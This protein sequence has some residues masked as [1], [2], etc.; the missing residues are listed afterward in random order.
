[1]LTPVYFVRDPELIKQITIKEFDHFVN[2]NGNIDEEIE[3][4]FGRSL[5]LMRDQRWK[6][7]RS[8]LSPAF[9]GS[10]MRNMFSL[11]ADC[12][13]ETIN[14]L[15]QESNGKPLEIE[16]KDL[17]TRQVILIFDICFSSIIGKSVL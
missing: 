3:P 5:F 6:D 17:F 7:M 13:N 12:S 8:T 4:M 1:M 9:T 2:H 10:K 14:Y 15:L 16:M 11:V